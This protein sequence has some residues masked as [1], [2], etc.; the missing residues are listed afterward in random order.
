[1]PFDF[2]GFKKGKKGADDEGDGDADLDESEA[3]DDEE[4]GEESEGD[5]EDEGGGGEKGKVGAF[6]AKFAFFAEFKGGGFIAG[7]KSN[8]RR[9]ITVV[10]GAVAALALVGGGAWFLIGGED[11]ADAAKSPGAESELE[12]GNKV[13]QQVPP[14]G[15]VI[16]LTRRDGVL[17]PPA[18]DGGDSEAQDAPPSETQDAPSSEAQDAPPSKEQDA[19]GE[20]DRSTGSLNAVA[21]AVREPGSGVS[22][23]SVTRASF[24]NIPEVKNAVPLSILPAKELTEDNPQ[25]P[26]PKIGADGRKPWQVYARPFEAQGDH[27]RIAV[28]IIGMGLSRAATEAAIK[29]LPGEITLVFNP[30]VKDLIDWVGAARKAG[31]EILLSLPMEA[32]KFPIHDPGPLAM[33]SAL[34]PEQNIERLEYILSRLTNY[35]GVATAMGTKFSVDDKALRPILEA[36]NSRGLM[37]IDGSGDAKSL[38]PKIATEISLPR[39]VGDLVLDEDPSKAAIDAQ[40]VKLEGIAREKTVAVAFAEPNPSTLERLSA[41]AA[42]LKGK[43]LTLAPISAVADRQVVK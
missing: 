26:L 5:E 32:E 13:V 8:K 7:L 24:R 28:I 39:A 18:E 42:T 22:A 2:K 3:V 38:T 14:K 29:Q 33:Q 4:E 17:T 1:M 9:M 21:A 10:G 43:N 12:G 27:P 31:H 36:I 19:G 11:P 35:V 30:H 25:G 20:Q 15:G 37:L 34:K 23:A 6:L 16:K 40:L 41:W